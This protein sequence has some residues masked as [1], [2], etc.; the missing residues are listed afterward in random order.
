MGI[1]WWHLPAP[2]RFSAAR[3]APPFHPPRNTVGNFCNRA[4]EKKNPPA[5]RLF[6]RLSR[7]WTGD[8]TENPATNSQA[9]AL[10]FFK[11]LAIERQF[12]LGF[13]IAPHS[14]ISERELVVRHGV[15]RCELH[16]LFQRRYSLR[17]STRR[18]Q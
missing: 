15:A 8:I 12:L 5:S 16:G 14:P 3:K 7:L 9:G 4:I 18:D 2:T 1:K 10:L 13:R 6:R 17:R 11:D